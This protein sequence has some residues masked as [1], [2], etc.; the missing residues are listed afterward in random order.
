[1]L[2]PLYSDGSRKESCRAIDEY[3]KLN[4]SPGLLTQSTF[5]IE[6]HMYI[7]KT[8]VKCIAFYYGLLNIYGRDRNHAVG[9]CFVV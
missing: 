4:K 9:Q 3:V 1:M 6:K 5:K 2:P 7:Q 8:V